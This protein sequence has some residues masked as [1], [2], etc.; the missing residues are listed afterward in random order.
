M[1]RG[2]SKEE[3]RWERRGR[4]E[5]GNEGRKGMKLYGRRGEKRGRGEEGEKQSNFWRQ[6]YKPQTNIL[7]M[8]VP[9]REAFKIIRIITILLSFS[10]RRLADIKWL[11][12]L[13]WVT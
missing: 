8:Y 10:L 13:M 2:R 11:T 9:F 12:Y 4:N 7:L 5:R 6:Q 1:W 3:R